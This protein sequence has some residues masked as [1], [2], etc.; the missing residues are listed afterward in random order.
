[1][2]TQNN[3]PVSTTPVEPKRRGPAP[4]TKKT[5]KVAVNPALTAFTSIVSILTPLTVEDRSK[6]LAHVDLHFKN[7]TASTEI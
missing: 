3:L 1:M 6:A 5:A 4:G 2:S 7:E